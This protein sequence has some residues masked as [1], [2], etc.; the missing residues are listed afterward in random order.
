MHE[1]YFTVNP[2]KINQNNFSLSKKES[3]HFLKSRRGKIHEEIWLLD[4]LGTAYHACVKEIDDNYVKGTIIDSFS[5]YGESK[6]NVNLII[7]LIKGRRM[8]MVFEKATELGVK[9]IQPLLVD[10]CIKNKLN[11]KRAEEIIIS[12][13]I[14]G[15]GGSYQPTSTLQPGKG[16]WVNASA[17]G[18]VTL[19]SG[20]A[21]RIKPFVDRAADANVIR[22]NGMPLYFGVTI[23]ENEL[24]SYELPPKPPAGASDVRFKGGWRLV[25]DYGEVEVMNTSETLTISHDIQMEPGEHFYWALTSETG[26]EIVLDGT[27]EIVVASSER[28]ILERKALVPLVFTLH[29]NFP[30]PF[31][32]NTQIHFTLGKDEL[33][34]LNIF[35]IQGRLVNSLIN[36]SNFPPGY[37][38]ITWDGTS[39][40]GTQV[41]SGMYL[42]KLVSENQTITRKM[43]LMK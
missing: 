19:N 5:N 8:D 2:S 14:Y 28:F 35:D 24:Q 16:Y 12:G 30:N 17:D 26:D 9:S 29:Q 34:S 21:A 6:L 3:D 4:G 37:H 23:P 13:S 7:G 1:N 40:I 31:N 10:H 43:V 20:G 33:V 39:A 22:F 41:P 38:N 25:E 32:P 42:Y 15:F 27:G 18:E 11:L 36:N